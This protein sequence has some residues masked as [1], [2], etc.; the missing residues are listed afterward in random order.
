MLLPP[1]VQSSCVLAFQIDEETKLAT[2]T[3]ESLQ[4]ELPISV[5]EHFTK[6]GL[7]ASLKKSAKFKHKATTPPV[8]QLSQ[9]PFQHGSACCNEER[10][11]LHEADTDRMSSVG[12]HTCTLISQG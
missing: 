6:G 9:L 7:K 10:S 8:S 11:H 3:L 2:E 4:L 1:N 5:E 12:N